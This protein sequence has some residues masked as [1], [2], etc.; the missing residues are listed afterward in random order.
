[1]RVRPTLMIAEL[2]LIGGIIVYFK[3]DMMTAAHCMHGLL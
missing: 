1:M 2:E 3:P